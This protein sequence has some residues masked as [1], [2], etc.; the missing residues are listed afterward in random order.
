M[1]D[2]DDFPRFSRPAPTPPSKA[3]PNTITVGL[4][5]DGQVSILSSPDAPGRVEAQNMI[6]PRDTARWLARQILLVTD[7]ATELPGGDSDG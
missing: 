4:R 5:T 6:M 2:R 7:D 1:T 3:Q